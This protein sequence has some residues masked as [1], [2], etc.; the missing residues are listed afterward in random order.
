MEHGVDK[1][2]RD[3]TRT[4]KHLELLPVPATQK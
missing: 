4:G 3:N 1:I 2:Y